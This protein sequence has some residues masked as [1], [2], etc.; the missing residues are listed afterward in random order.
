MSFINKKNLQSDIP[1]LLNT[2]FD[3]INNSTYSIKK[4]DY[5]F[6]R[7]EIYE[8]EFRTPIVPKDIPFFIFHN[9][10]I[11]IQTSMNRIFEENEYRKYGAQITDL[12]WYELDF[13]DNI[14]LWIIGIKELNN[15]EEVLK[16]KNFYTHLYFAHCYK[17]QPYAEN[18]L[19]YFKTSGSILYDFEYFS[20]NGKRQIAFGEYAGFVGCALGLIQYS[21][22]RGMYDTFFPIDR[23][24][25]SKKNLINDC[26]SCI[27]YIN[28]KSKT[29]SEK[30][31]EQE[32]PTKIAIIGYGRCSRGVQNFLQIF[33]I[34]YQIFDKK[35]DKSVLNTYNIIFNCI[36]LNEKIPV[37]FDETTEFNQE[38]VIVDI[39]CDYSHPFNPIS[40]Y[41]SKTT[42]E[43]P[44]F[45]YKPNVSVIAI[46]NL[47]S[48][49]P[50]ESSTEFSDNFKNLFRLYLQGDIN[51]VWENNF[52]L[53][54][55]KINSSNIS[56]A[57]D[58]DEIL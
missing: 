31:F 45:Y 9:V 19:D 7:R 48:L 44:V 13:V 37:W 58:D 30:L 33:D 56:N 34:D 38:T 26:S 20:I 16:K 39:S 55:S 36:H 17:K 29:S 40:I 43:E 14:N 50:N 23:P 35:S 25:N 47:P 28:K 49:L 12:E 57:D 52:L 41:N 27:S 46:D 32:S 4:P 6:I 3:C 51:Q 11:I 15:P 8:N 10:G 21:I 2:P 53:F 42:W 1:N 22:Q 54:K 24:W 5:I 18:L